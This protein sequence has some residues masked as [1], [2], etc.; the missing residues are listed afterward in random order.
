MFLTS[1][2][3]DFESIVY[4]LWY[5]VDINLYNIIERYVSLLN[6]NSSSSW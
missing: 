6:S 4:L 2:R 5:F 3:N 1:F